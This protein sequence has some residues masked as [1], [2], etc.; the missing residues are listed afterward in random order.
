MDNHALEHLEQGASM[1]H[2]TVAEDCYEWKDITTEFTEWTS[3]MHEGELLSIPSFTLY[4]AMSAIELMDHK[5]D[6]GLLL[7]NRRVS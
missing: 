6:V 3:E 2:I 4:D 1:L 5:M 7:K